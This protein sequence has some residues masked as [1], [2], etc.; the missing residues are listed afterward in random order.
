MVWIGSPR[1]ELLGDQRDRRAGGLTDAERQM[2]GRPAPDDQG[3]AVG[4]A[5]GAVVLQVRRDLGHNFRSYL[6]TVKLRPLSR[7]EL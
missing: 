5:F 3:V 4:V 7:D 6:P 1:G 2:P